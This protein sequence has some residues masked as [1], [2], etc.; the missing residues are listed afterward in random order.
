MLLNVC[1]ISSLLPARTP[2]FQAYSINTAYENK[3]PAFL[4]N[5]RSLATISGNCCLW[6]S[7]LIE[8]LRKG[9]RTL[10][11]PSLSSVKPRAQGTVFFL[12]VKDFKYLNSQRPEG[13]KKG[14]QKSS[15][16]HCNYYNQLFHTE[17]HVV[18]HIPLLL[19]N[20]QLEIQ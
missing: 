13:K 12:E 3:P 15:L 6:Y 19:K 20:M 1:F 7:T 5:N 2:L 11:S 17:K 8:D 4:E 9:E 18:L 14:N 10:N 16:D